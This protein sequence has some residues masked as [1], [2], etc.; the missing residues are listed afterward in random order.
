MFWQ[1]SSSRTIAPQIEFLKNKILQNLINFLFLRISPLY[2][3]SVVPDP[4]LNLFKYY[5]AKFFA[6]PF[7]FEKRKVSQLRSWSILQNET[8]CPKSKIS[9]LLLSATDLS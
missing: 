3:L 2:V 4:P 8:F 6:T 5:V 7:F 1:S 9:P